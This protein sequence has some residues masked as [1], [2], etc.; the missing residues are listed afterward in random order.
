MANLFNYTFSYI[1]KTLQ[2]FADILSPYLN[3]PQPATPTLQEVLDNNH[4]LVNGNNFQGTGSGVSNTGNDVNAFGSQSAY[5]NTNN[6]VNAIGK[7]AAYQNTGYNFTAIGKSA[8]FQNAGNNS[9]GIGVEALRSNIGSQVIGLGNFAAFSNQASNICAIGFNSANNNTINN[10][11]IISNFFLPSYANRAAA[12]AA[13]TGG[14]AGST[15]LY[16]N[17]T[18]FAIEGVRFA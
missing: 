14:S 12:V 16:Y 4:D 13:I 8:G 17:Q 6:D 1:T 10:S 3:I 9:I 7:Q 15:Y 11:F 2:E 5:E 18:T